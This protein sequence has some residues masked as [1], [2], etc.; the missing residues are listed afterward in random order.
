MQAEQLIRE[1]KI[2]EALAALQDAARSD[3]ANVEY[4]AFLYQLLC[5]MGQWDRALTQINVVGDMKPKDLIMVEFYRNAIR[6]EVLRNEVFAGKR[7]PLMLG[8]PKEW[9]GLMVQAVGHHARGEISAAAS[10]RDQAFDQAPAIEGT[11]NGEPFSW[12]ADTDHRLG[13]IMEVIIQGKYYWA[14]FDHISAIKIEPPGTL[15]DVVWA[16]AEFIWNNQGKAVGL[17]PVRYPGTAE[18]GSDA[19]KLSRGTSFADLAEDYC[20]GTGQRMFASDSGETPILEA[21]L[22]TLG[23]QGESESEGESDG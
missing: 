4:R 17:I 1:G 7:T 2:A 5:V 19:E 23:D 18:R 10:L 20:V 9:L 11:I 22:I 8:E 15:R 14:P 6:C 12:L 13:P 3:P 21:R 16:Q